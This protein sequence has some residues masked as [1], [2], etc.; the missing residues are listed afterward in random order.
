MISVWLCVAPVDR[1]RL[2]RSKALLNLYV[3]WGV[4]NL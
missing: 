4:S 2:E 1:N 3:G